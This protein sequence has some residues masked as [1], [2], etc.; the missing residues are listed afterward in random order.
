M[1]I[2]I[3]TIEYVNDDNKITSLSLSFY[4][5]NNIIDYSIH[6][7]FDILKLNG[8]WYKGDIIINDKAYSYSDINT[9]DV[10]LFEIKDKEYH[11]YFLIKLDEDKIKEYKD[12]LKSLKENNKHHL[13]DIYL[14][15][16]EA[17]LCLI[18]MNDQINK[19]NKDKI[20][21]TTEGLD[22]ISL[23]LLEEKKVIKVKT[24]NK[25]K[26]KKEKFTRVKHINRKD[27]LYFVFIFFSTLF[28]SL[29][30][31]LVPNLF[32]MKNIGVAITL[33]VN[34]ILCFIID[35]ILLIDLFISEYE[36]DK[37]M[38]AILLAITEGIIILGSLSG[39]L[40]YYLFK[41]NKILFIFTNSETPSI[42]LAYIW[43]SVALII[44]TII[45]CLLANKMKKISD[46]ILL[47]FKK[48]KKKHDKNK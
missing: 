18:D 15:F 10:A 25:K 47:A 29:F 36:F 24:N 13:V 6:E 3:P 48:K 8:D 33:L 31:L 42:Y 14:L 7:I 44:L 5:G 37:K 20:M 27:Y 28:T 19:V 35:L 16:N 39:Y 21:L 41:E 23:I 26:E 22:M 17:Y 4:K 32:L 45:F 43:T 46:K 1:K 34:S 12:K 9:T 38:K 2:Y 30:L 40:I 11:L